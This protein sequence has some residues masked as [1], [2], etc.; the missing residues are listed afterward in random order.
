MQRLDFIYFK[1]SPKGG[2]GVFTADYIP[3]DTLI[4]IC[5]V[6]VLSNEDREKIHQT[7]L[8]DYYFLWDKEGKQA[9]IALGYGSLYNHSY[10][11]NAYYQMNK[12]G[13][14]IDVYAGEDIEPGQ[15][16]CFNYN[17]Q[18]FDD[19]PLWFEAK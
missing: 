11:P 17:G 19:S 5:P 9:A 7:F 2:R 15:E 8:H 12:D 10:Q 16:I 4:E 6:L 1:D 18:R 13:Q 14:S 3:K